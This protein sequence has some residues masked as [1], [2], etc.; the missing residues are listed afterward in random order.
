MIDVDKIVTISLRENE[1]R[2][3]L[4]KSELLKLNLKTEFFI[5]D[6]DPENGERGC[7]NSHLQV[8]QQALADQCQSVL[9][10]EDDVKIL[11]FT[12]KQITAINQFI[13]DQDK[14]NFDVLYLGL[15]IGEMWFC[16]RRSIVRA[17]GATTHAYIL[18]KQ[19]LKKLSNYLFSGKPIDKIFKHDF[20]CYSVYPIIAEQFSENIVS[21]DLTPFRQFSEIKD[22]KF[23]QNNYRKQ[24][25]LPWKN[26]H[27]IFTSL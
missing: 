15:I 18:S 5:A 26:L 13:K 7:F 24:K 21:S 23:W 20:K 11:P 12:A 10:F 16:G 6:R 8:C 14:I 9:V 17:K 22:E 1:E 2:R 19:G 27:K 3:K 4:T 25:W